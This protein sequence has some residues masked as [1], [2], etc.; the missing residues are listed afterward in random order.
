MYFCSVDSTDSAL[1]TPML[2][3]MSFHRCLGLKFYL[4]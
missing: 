4:S 1:P 3:F 2:R